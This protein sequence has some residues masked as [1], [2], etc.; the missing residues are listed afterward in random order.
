MS[1][2]ATITDNGNGLPDIGELCYDS[3]TDTVYM[4]AGWDG[5]DRIS[6][7]EPGCGNSVSVLLEE[8]G[9]AADTTDDEWRE[10]ENNNY[11]VSVG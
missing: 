1:I 2:K 8:H 5:S 7:G 10:I 3:T 4:V 6:T 11:G 9:C